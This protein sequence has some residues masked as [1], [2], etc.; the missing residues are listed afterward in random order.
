MADR[1]SARRALANTFFLT[2]N[3]GLVTLLGGNELRWYVA[4][5][6]IV[7]AL[8]WWSLLSTYRRLSWAKFAVISAAESNFVFQPFTQEWH[9]LAKISAPLR[10]WPLPD[11]WRWLKGYQDLGAFER[12]VPLTFAALYLVELVRQITH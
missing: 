2:L 10:L 5:A 9:L 12:V 7:L 6:G 11:M 1:L 4:A 8:A 3:T